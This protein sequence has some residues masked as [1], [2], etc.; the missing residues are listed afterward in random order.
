MLG[1]FSEQ[2]TNLYYNGG[3]GLITIAAPESGK[4]AAGILP[5]LIYYKGS[6]V[7]LDVKGECYRKTADYR[8][9]KYGKVFKFCPE[10]PEES[11]H[12]NPL[13]FIPK[14]KVAVWREARILADLINPITN[15]KSP[16]WDRPGQ[17]LLTLA[18]A[19][20]VLK[21]E[22]PH[23]GHVRRN[24]SRHL[25]TMLA[26]ITEN[27]DDYA[28]SIG[29]TA[30]KFFEIST[31]SEAQAS[32]IIGAATEALGFWADDGLAEI[33]QRN[34]WTP[35]ALREEGTTLYFGYR[36]HSCKITV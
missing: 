20:A 31:K 22:S 26:D 2:K 19:Y 24:L 25:N 9:R 6:A 17:E 3:R 11:A 32:G 33:I 16:E 29:D 7:V 21:N 34:D 5:N 35:E 8:R 10:K 4:T 12:Y 23:M 18:I 15:S 14:D 1:R 30:Y 13:A 27:E 36:A 28:Q